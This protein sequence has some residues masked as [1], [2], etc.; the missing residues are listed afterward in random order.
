LEQKGYARVNGRTVVD[1]ERP[2]HNEQVRGFNVNVLRLSDCATTDYKHFD[3][4]NE[5]AHGAADLALYLGSL[6][7]GTV[8]Y[9]AT[10]DDAKNALRDVGQNALLEIGINASSLTLRGKLTF[11]AVVGSPLS[12][13]FRIAQPGGDNLFMDEMVSQSTK[14]SPGKIT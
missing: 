5:A 7:P 8:V 9:G 13:V 6:A 1:Y 12:T 14:Y 11:V 10:C 3:T 4:W 2:D